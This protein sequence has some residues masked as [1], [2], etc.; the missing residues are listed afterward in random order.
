MI[1]GITDPARPAM[2]PHTA[3]TPATDAQG[4]IA[5]PALIAHSEQF[6]PRVHRVSDRIHCAVGFGLSNVTLILGD[7]GAILVD[8]GECREEMAEV[9]DAF[10]PLLDRP[11]V[12]IIYSHSHYVGGTAEVLARHPGPIPIYAHRAVPAV[13]AEV[14]A[15][16]GPSYLRRLKIQFA[17]DLPRQ[18]PDAMPNIGLGL[19]LFREGRR[20]PGF[21][22][23]THWFE[24]EQTTLRIAGLTV[25]IDGRY[26]S[27]SRDTIIIGLP[28]LDAVVNNH[29]WPVLFNIYP[30]RGEAYRDP[31]V[32]VRAIDRIREADPM[33]LVGVHGVPVSGREAVRQ[34]LLDH[35]D[36]IQYLWD[37]TVR[38]MN[39]GLSPDELAARIAL[40]ERLAGSRWIPMHYG[41]T[42][43]HVRAIHNGLL[44]WFGGD[45]ATL[46]P[47]APARRARLLV[48]AMGGRDAV[49]AQAQAA[50]DRDEVSWTAELCSHLL[51]LDPDDR[52]AGALKARALRWIAQR[53]PSANT[54]AFCLEEA[55]RWEAGRGGLEVV[56]SRP[57]RIGVL[58]APADRFVQA[59][60][61]RLDPDR[62]R[63]LDLVARWRFTDATLSCGLHVV[64]GVARFIAQDPAQ[65]REPARVDLG[66]S[67]AHA[68]WAQLLNGRLSL[69]AAL[70]QGLAAIDT[71]SLDGWLG[72]FD[73][74]DNLSMR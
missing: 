50:F 59:L 61:A 15:E 67:C 63:D 14:G 32:M 22:A 3:A 8:T 21:V 57:S 70:D 40:P 28:E 33:H 65:T 20:T 38:G 37:Q 2:N 35:R 49:L 52:P 27:D 44:G 29:V 68:T 64:G 31:L 18:G 1:D 9:L 55:R 74:F 24:P 16:I 62:S 51:R 66:L 19:S 60:G 42:P 7:E 11:V 46:H 10:G 71:G 6:R 25:N 47:V 34:C 54:R 17:H 43:Y 39:Q 23:P 5:H 48:D 72:L 45:A 36:S 56:P 4:A 41:E 58:N 53:T 12:A 26:A 73:A 30:L 13:M 69:P